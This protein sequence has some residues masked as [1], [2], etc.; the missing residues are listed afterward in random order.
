MGGAS[1]QT[2]GIGRSDQNSLEKNLDLRRQQRPPYIASRL[3]SGLTVIQAMAPNRHRA[4]ATRN[5]AVQP[6]CNAITGVS[7]AVT[8]PPIC[9][10]I[11]IKPETEPDEVLLRS[12]VTD[13]KELCARYNAPAPPAKTTLANWA[14]RTSAPM[15][16]NTPASA[17]AAAAK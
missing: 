16:R 9:A 6:K 2:S 17:I 12:A 4:A 5:E 3:R 13:Q 11:F 1:S 10:P 8:A 7:D 14:L 15:T